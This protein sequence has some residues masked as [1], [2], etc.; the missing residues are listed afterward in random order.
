MPV[1]GEWITYGDQTGYF[2]V[3]DQAAPPLPGVVVI[4]EI[5][6]VNDNI[7]DITRRIAASGYAALAPDIYAVKGK[8]PEAL[9]SERLGETWAFAA[10]LPPGSRFDPA[11]REAA[12]AKLDEAKRS[13]INESSGMLFSG[14]NR[15][16]SFIPCL[17]ESVRYLKT[18]RPETKGRKTGCVGFC[19][20]GGLSALLACEEPE[21][22]GAAMFYGNAPAPEK[23]PNIRCPVI[24]FYA[25][26][27]ARV[28]EGI[29]AFE[30]AMRKAGKSFE[31]RMYDGA[32]HGFFNDCWPLY[33]VNASRDSWARLL[34]FFARNLT[35]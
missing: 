1:K 10:T 22:S 2:A 20:G 6:G 19:M 12:L 21:L 9:S 17:R 13:R 8:R 29:P 16:P 4:Q 23:I 34:A 15:M 27:D 14:L 11:A 28:N 5:G 3:P 35:D 31:H 32:N 7:E 18:E 24:A 30:Q 25:G 33:D 26:E